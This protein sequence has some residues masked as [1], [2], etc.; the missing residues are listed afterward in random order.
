[1]RTITKSI[2]KYKINLENESLIYRVFREVKIAP[3]NIHL[4]TLKNLAKACV[5]ICA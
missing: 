2:K 5:S 3:V 4:P 1:M